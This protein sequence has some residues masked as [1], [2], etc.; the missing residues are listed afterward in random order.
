MTR[1]D[2]VESLVHD[3]WTT[4]PDLLDV[5]EA[6]LS[7]LL[8]DEIL[9]PATWI[10]FLLRQAQMQVEIV[11]VRPLAESIKGF[12]QVKRNSLISSWE[13]NVEMKLEVF[14]I[15]LHFIRT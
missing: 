10:D 2:S 4:D 7:D 1:Q 14:C 5:L 6:E 13:R 15:D 11:G 8:S 3:W 12:E 9:I